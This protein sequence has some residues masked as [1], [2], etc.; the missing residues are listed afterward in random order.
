MCSK[1]EVQQTISSSTV[2]TKVDTLMSMPASQV[3]VFTVLRTGRCNDLRCMR[4][5]GA[6]QNTC[7]CK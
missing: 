1:S 7:R 4:V 3:T 5:L 6:E 2:R